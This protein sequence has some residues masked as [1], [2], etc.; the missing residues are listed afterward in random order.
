VQADAGREFDHILKLQVTG[1][2]DDIVAAIE[3]A[4]KY[5]A[6]TRVPSSGSSR[7]RR[8]TELSAGR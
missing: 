5:G 4:T 1:S 2:V 7:E 6:S 8:R 3:H